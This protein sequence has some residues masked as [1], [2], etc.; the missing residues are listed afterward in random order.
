MTSLA[1]LYLFKIVA[2]LV[3]WCVPLLLFS[4]A[5]FAKMGIVL[6]T[7]LGIRLLGPGF[8]LLPVKGTMS[9]KM[10]D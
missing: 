3:F 1:K 8:A 4:P 9:R 7:T 10:A 2:T 6:P 5:F